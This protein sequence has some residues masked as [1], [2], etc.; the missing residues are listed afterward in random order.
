MWGK[1]QLWSATHK[2]SVWDWD[3]AASCKATGIISITPAHAISFQY[4][5]MWKWLQSSDPIMCILCMVWYKKHL[6]SDSACHY[7]KRCLLVISFSYMYDF[8]MWDLQ[9]LQM[10]LSSS[11]T[12][13]IYCTFFALSGSH[14]R[15]RTPLVA[16]SWQLDWR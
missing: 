8:E 5:H 11:N 9:K 6:F 2:H 14:T 15:C 10:L 4:L 3:V 12:R 13:Q 7:Y 16:Y 1:E